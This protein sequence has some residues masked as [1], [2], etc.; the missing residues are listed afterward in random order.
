MVQWASAGRQRNRLLR[1][2]RK[3]AEGS[4][5]TIDWWKERKT[6][7]RETGR[8]YMEPQRARGRPMYSAEIGGNGRTYI[9]LTYSLFHHTHT[10]MHEHTL[11][12]S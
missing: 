7:R 5:R 4:E 1:E 6:E 10:Y 8:G 11:K 2:S 9:S 3:Q 12:R